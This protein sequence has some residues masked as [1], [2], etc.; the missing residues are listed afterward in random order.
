MFGYLIEP[1]LELLIVILIFSIFTVVSNS[2]GIK[3]VN[4][5]MKNKGIKKLK[6]NPDKRGEFPENSPENI[7]AK[8]ESENVVEQ[9]NE[10]I[11]EIK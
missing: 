1:P 2:L 4:K 6:I 7:Y 9:G 8:L 3:S 5:L 10:A 11:V